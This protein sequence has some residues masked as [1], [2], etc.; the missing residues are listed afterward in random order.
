[1]KIREGNAGDIREI[2]AITHSL[3]Q[4]FT[5]TGLLLIKKDLRCQKVLVADSGTKV[6]G[7]LRLGN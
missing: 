4:W 2:L 5:E 1:M 6:D 7:F 3:P